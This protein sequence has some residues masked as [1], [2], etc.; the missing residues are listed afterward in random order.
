MKEQRK[1]EDRRDLQRMQHIWQNSS[2]LVKM[3]MSRTR[4]E[5][6]LRIYLKG[7]FFYRFFLKDPFF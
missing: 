7:I 2:F 1:L 4:N 5:K 6:I 3:K